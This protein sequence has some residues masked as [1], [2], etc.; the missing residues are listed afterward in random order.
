MLV[1]LIDLHQWALLKTLA[2][3]GCVEE[4]SPTLKMVMTTTRTTKPYL[5]NKLV[6]SLLGSITWT[7]K[8]CLLNYNAHPR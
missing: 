8:V 7:L 3:F 1:W 2:A 6:A 5:N 4:Y